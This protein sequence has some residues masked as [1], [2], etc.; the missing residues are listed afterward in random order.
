MK[1][2]QSTKLISFVHKHEHGS[3][4]NLVSSSGLRISIS[5]G[6]LGAAGVVLAIKF[7]RYLEFSS[8]DASPRSWVVPGLENLGN[9][10]FLNVV[11]QV[12]SAY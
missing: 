10:C 11:L 8:S 3:K 5:V 1:I 7:K 9:N 12:S 2:L 4:F 6:L